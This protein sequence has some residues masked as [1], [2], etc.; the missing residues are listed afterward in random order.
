MVHINVYSMGMDVQINVGE[1]LSAA[2]PS[3]FR[4]YQQFSD[5]LLLTLPI[6]PNFRLSP[7]PSYAK[8]S[9]S[10]INSAQKIGV[11]GVI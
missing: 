5:I 2:I 9:M 4:Y 8:L 3:S 11:Y 6:Y 10:T 1:N 7:A